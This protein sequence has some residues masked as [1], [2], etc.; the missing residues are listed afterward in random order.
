MKSIPLLSHIHIFRPLL[1]LVPEG[2]SIVQQRF[3]ILMHSVEM[4]RAG[5]WNDAINASCRTFSRN[6][7]L[8][9]RWTI[10]ATK[11]SQPIAVSF[12]Y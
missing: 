10:C 12:C 11:E 8:L 4:L 3:K 9:L 5:E 2:I 7:A 1:C 6:F